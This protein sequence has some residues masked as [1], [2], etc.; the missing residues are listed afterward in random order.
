MKDLRKLDQY[1]QRRF[2]VCHSLAKEY[3]SIKPIEKCYL[4]SGS[5]WHSE[6]EIPRS[7]TLPL[8]DEQVEA[9]KSNLVEVFNGLYPDD[10]VKDWNEFEEVMADDLDW[11]F[12]N[13]MNN[14]RGA[15]NDCI[16][17]PAESCDIY[18]D[19][20][21]FKHVRHLYHF[22][23]FVYE[24]DEGE[25]SGPHKF[26]IELEDDDYAFLLALQLTMRKG[27]TYNTLSE[28]DPEFV[29]KLN[30]NIDFNFFDIDNI[31]S[32]TKPFLIIFDEV[33]EDA[34][35]LKDESEKRL[36]DIM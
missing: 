4:V 17:V 9:I 6:G 33:I 24:A 32:K 34:K 31:F 1:E 13:E 3:L 15:W 19:D 27:L 35:A 26:A 16:L 21:D 30:R 11:D 8:T 18:P 14:S 36:H 5:D 23:A 29:L 2:D 20:I 28:V 25:M 10:P 7:M 22:S 12:W